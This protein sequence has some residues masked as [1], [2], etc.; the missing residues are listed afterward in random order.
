VSYTGG[1]IS[2][3]VLRF[4][5]PGSAH[6]SKWRSIRATPTPVESLR[7]IASPLSRRLELGK[8]KRR[9]HTFALSYFDEGLIDDLAQSFT[10]FAESFGPFVKRYAKPESH[11]V[12]FLVP[13]IK[14]DFARFTIKVIFR[15]FFVYEVGDVDL[16]AG[17]LSLVFQI[18]I[19]E[20]AV[21]RTSPWSI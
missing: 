5:L 11:H 17:F 10:R 2:S 1:L 4:G 19:D 8:L 6:I 9:F 20:L 15:G 7:I 3:A 16:E 21:F 18:S 12:N 14:N 13:F